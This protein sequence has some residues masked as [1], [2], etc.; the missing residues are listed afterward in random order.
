MSVRIFAARALIERHLF[1]TS[2]AC[3]ATDAELQNRIIR[4]HTMNLRVVARQPHPD[5]YHAAHGAAPSRSCCAEPG[6]SPIGRFGA[7]DLTD[8]VMVPLGSVLS[9]VR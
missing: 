9:Q 5:P 8:E 1:E 6:G 2:V 4:D 3:T 7:R